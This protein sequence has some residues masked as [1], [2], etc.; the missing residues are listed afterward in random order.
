MISVVAGRLERALADACGVVLAALLALV[1]ITTFQRYAL[2][3]GWLGAEEAAAWLLVLLACLGFPL[4][5]GGPLSMS[6]DLFPALR[7]GPAAARGMV[8]EAVILTASV[9]F[10]ST[11]IQ[12]ALR[13][14]GVSALL[15]LGEWMRPAML[16]GAG[17]LAIL[18]R[19][20]VLA[21]E[22]GRSRLIP[23]LAVAAVLFLAVE[24]G[25]A[26]D[27]VPPSLMAAIVVAL[28]ILVAAP[29]PHVFIAAGY[30]ALLGGSPLV[31]PAIALQLLSGL[32]RYLLLAVPFFLLT[33]GLL[34]VSGMASDLVRLA[35][36]LVGARRAGLGQTVLLTSVLFSGISG[37]SIANAA[38]SAKTFLKP[39][40]ASGY[41]PERAGAIIAAA[42]VLDN[43]I[44][45]SI[46]FL[47]LAAATDLP[48]GPLLVGGLVGGLVLAAALAVAIHVVGGGQGLPQ[49][50]SEPRRVLALRALPVLGLGLVVVAGIR[51]GL[52]TPTE[53]AGLAAL[54]TLAAALARRGGRRGIAD[55]FR[56]SGAEAAAILVLIG[57]AAPLSFLLATDGVAA[58]A[59]RA[60]LLLGDNPV[61][62]MIAANLLLLVVG[63]ALDI[64]AG[65][66]LFAPI[67]LPVAVAVGIDPVWFGVVLV[68]NLMIGGL[69]PPVGIL[70]Q[71][72]SAATG[73]PATALFCAVLPYM[74][75]L[76][77][78]LFSIGLFVAVWS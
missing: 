74:A 38:F 37:S 51:F 52:V 55:A 60:A 62:V 20:A 7:G 9:A 1:A 13:V 22:D 3:S 23:G 69:T 24:T 49:T 56:Q 32:G 18:L 11:G 78:A 39:L 34:I 33:G 10:V 47:I 70:V 2:G 40:T 6:I 72:V 73:L 35:G 19:L 76:L 75:A 21:R 66:L 29:L 41:A 77:A 43:I 12:A 16:A 25:V 63:L 44:P 4:A 8:A 5:S 28:G 68:I 57:A 46:A 59:A 36:S 14:G 27:A 31:E 71:V 64:G 42:S 50:P 54:Y 61:M 45:P 26:T 48:V 65:I 67:L 58:S 15:G 30:L 17:A 53:A